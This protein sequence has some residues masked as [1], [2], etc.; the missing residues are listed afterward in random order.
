MAADLTTAVEKFRSTPAPVFGG[1]IAWDLPVANGKTLIDVREALVRV[2]LPAELLPERSHRETMALAIELFESEHEKSLLVRKIRD[3]AESIVYGIV[4]E[5]KDKAN[6]KLRYRQQTTVNMN[7]STGHLIGEGPHFE[8]FRDKFAWVASHAL[9]VDLQKIMREVVHMVR[10][11]AYRHGGGTYFYAASDK[12]VSLTQAATEFVK[13]LGVSPA[14]V[15]NI[16]LSGGPIQ[17]A[18]IFHV[19]KEEV[20]K[21]IEGIRKAAENVTKRASSLSNHEAQLKD[22]EEL[23]EYYLSLTQMEEA[24][25][26]READAKTLR[27]MIAETEA[28]ISAKVAEVEKMRKSA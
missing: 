17:K 26:Q 20:R 10:G 8:A 15:S 9:P 7:K 16:P 24:E 11:I 5:G 25:E 2:G 14:H 13:V 4:K 18:E 6:D 1:L 22:V 23:M 3:D 12:N 19:A 21:Q 27:D 28:F